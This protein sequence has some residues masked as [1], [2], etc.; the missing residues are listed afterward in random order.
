MKRHDARMMGYL[1]GEEQIKQQR[2]LAN[3]QKKQNEMA[4]A[5]EAN[6][7][8]MLQLHHTGYRSPYPDEQSTSIWDNPVQLTQPPIYTPPGVPGF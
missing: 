2:L 3:I 7:Q 5:T 8:R 1:A 4:N 6:R